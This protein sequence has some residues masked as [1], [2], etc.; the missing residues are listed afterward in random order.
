MEKIVLSGNYFCAANRRFVAVGVNWVPSRQA[1]QW[2]YEWD[3]ASIEADF[4]A[5]AQLGINF[6]RFDLVW[7][8]FETRPGQY[9]EAAFRQF[10]YLVG[11]AHK[12]NIYLNPAFFIGGEVGDA[13]WDVPWRNGRHPHSDPEM[14]HLEANHVAEFG[15]RYK[16]E[17]AILAWDLTDEPPFWIVGD[18]TTDPMASNW[19][20]LLC[21]SLRAEDPEHLIV[22]GNAAQEIGRGP[23]RIDNIKTWVDFSSVHPYPIYEPFLY[24]E[25]LLS[26]RLTYAAAFETK[27][28]QGA[29]KPVLMQEFGATSSM[30]SPERQGKYY[31]TMMYSALGAGSQGFIA[32][33]ATDAHPTIQFDRAPYKRDPHETQFGITDFERKPRPNGLEML[34]IRQVM[35]QLDLA[36][37]EPAKEEAAILVP[38]EWAYGSDYTQYNF[39][40]DTAYQYSPGNILNEHTDQEANARIQQAWLSAYILCRQAGLLAGFPRELDKEWQGRKLVLTPS[41]LTNTGGYQ[42][43]VPFWQHVL[44][45]VAGGGSLYASLSAMSA[46]SLPFVV[47]LF[48]VSL[49]DRLPWRG[50]ITLEFTRPFAGI[51]KGEKFTFQA[52][53]G[54]LYTGARLQIE[55]AQVLAIDQDGNPAFVT[56]ETGQGRTALCAYPIEMMLGVT[57]NA[58][59]EETNYWKIYRALKTWA[60]VRSPYTV[61]APQVEVG[62]LSS[63]QRDYVV[64]VNH[65]ASPKEGRV[66]VTGNARKILKVEH[67]TPAGRKAISPQA[68][69]FEYHLEGFS[70]TVFEVIK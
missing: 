22:C 62:L 2:P 4:S 23:F 37:V 47:D 36:G 12:Y 29:G 63:S 49:E 18:S 19:T 58:L 51:S 10:D 7:G 32:W 6:I 53:E 61:T 8:W 70:G 60:G 39:P 48:G 30:Y 66:A 1:M 20:R 40:A 69:G 59:E 45:W 65:S 41:P 13:Y 21:H 31:R 25:P 38:H 9:N 52:R 27:L 11:L 15:R 68:T 54:L 67:L 28:T 42:L 43:Y 5:M 50:E 24:N 35:D 44:P 56:F 14:L 17:A 33:C 3:P 64:L 34:S 26:T 16:A 57:P 46:L 55:G